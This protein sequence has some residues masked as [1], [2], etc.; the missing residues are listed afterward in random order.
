MIAPC[1]THPICRR[2]PT[3]SR[4][5]FARVYPVLTTSCPLTVTLST[6]RRFLVALTGSFS[7]SCLPVRRSSKWLQNFGVCPNNLSNVGGDFTAGR[8]PFRSYECYCL[9]V[10]VGS[11]YGFLLTCRR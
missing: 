11:V 8:K 2:E 6:S 10:A 7:P 1:S 9:S 3:S 4:I 5:K